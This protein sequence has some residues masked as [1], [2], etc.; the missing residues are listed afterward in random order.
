[1]NDTGRPMMTADP[2]LQLMRTRRICHAF[3]D[4]P[5]ARC[6]IEMI[7]EAGRWASSAGNVRLHRFLIVQEPS[8][9]A[10]AKSVSPGMWAIPPVL[11]VICTD[12]DVAAR[13]QVQVGR[14]HCQW[15]DVG[16][17]AMNMMLEAHALALGSCPASSFSPGGLRTVLDLPSTA[18]PELLIQLGHPAP[19]P[20]A[21]P[22]TRRP[23][24]R[25]ADLT[26][27]EHYPTDPEGTPR[28]RP[29]AR[30]ASDPRESS[31]VTDHVR[32]EDRG[33]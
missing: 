19:S 15:I 5:V 7:I 4:E 10:L 14:D 30:L 6:D 3:S 18:I 22:V 9:I 12:L 11:I 27:W 8:R 2:L 23:R 33:P 21:A 29:G 28:L 16:T 25:A 20:K 1:M 24:L 26:Y 13:A 32:R 31:F 17:A